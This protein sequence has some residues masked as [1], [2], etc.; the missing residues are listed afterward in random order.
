MKNASSVYAVVEQTVQH[1]IAMAEKQ[2]G[3]TFKMPTIEYFNK[4]C[5]GGDATPG[6]WRVR[7]NTVLLKDNLQR[8]LVRTIPHEVAHLI[9]YAVHG[10]EYNSA[11]KCIWHGASFKAQMQAFGCETTRCHNMDTSEIKQKKRNTAKHAVKCT[12]CG[13]IGELGTI[14]KNKILRGAVYWHTGGKKHILE[15]V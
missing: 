13:W 5:T 3:R 12:Y 1:Y 11:G 6:K 2:H 7:F 10:Y 8:Y 15:L 9:C 14:H 4:G